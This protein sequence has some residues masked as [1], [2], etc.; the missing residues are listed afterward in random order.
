MKKISVF[1]I[2]TILVI[3]CV[4]FVG[5]GSNDVPDNTP[6]KSITLG[7]YM[8]TAMGSEGPIEWD[9]LKVED[10]KA[11]IISHYVLTELKFDNGGSNN[12]ADSSI[13]KF[14]NQDFYDMA[15]TEEE[16]ARILTTTVDNSA[17]T[18]EDAQNV[19]ACENTED[20]IFLLSYKEAGAI[21]YPL[22]E[23]RIAEGTKWAYNLRGD[24]TAEYTFDWW[25]RSPSVVGGAARTITK[26][27]KISSVTASTY[28][29]V[30]PACWVTL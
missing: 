20:K 28:K 5:C 4:C 1:L 29:G 26:E 12:Y 2:F 7:N 3:T 30:R 25:T 18:T 24:Y 14:L 19:F 21:Y 16:K 13:R 9:V 10:G 27:G 6:P 15:F 23:N 11:L 8:Y 17:A 22:T